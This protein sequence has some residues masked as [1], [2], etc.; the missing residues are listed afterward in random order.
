[1]STN[2]ANFAPASSRRAPT[3]NRSPHD[4][5]DIINMTYPFPDKQHLGHP[6]ID[7]DTRAAEFAPFAALTG[8][9]ETINEVSETIDDP[10][11]LTL[12]LFRED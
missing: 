3:A 9:H 10:N 5:D 4:Y 6:H 11:K 8:Y 12:E 1:M 7:P 2:T